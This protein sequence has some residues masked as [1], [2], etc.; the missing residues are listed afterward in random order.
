MAKKSE[1][2]RLPPPTLVIPGVEAASKIQ[3]QI[4]K[5]NGILEHPIGSLEELERLRKEYY[6]W[7]SYNTELLTRF[8]DNQSIADE[9][10]LWIGFAGGRQSPSEEIRDFRRDVQEKISRLQSILERLELISESPKATA[11][12]SL[13][14]VAPNRDVFVVH[15]WDGGARDVVSRFI[16]KLGLRAIVLHEQPSEG[17]TVIEKL[18]AHSDVG[19]AIILLTPDDVGYP[20]NK[21]QE[22]RQRARQNVIFELGYFLGKLGRN[23]VCALHKGEVEL[24]SDYHGV[25]YIR[26]DDNGGWQLRLA[27]EMKQGGM[28][29]DL[30]KVV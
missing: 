28:A 7:S 11:F 21:P 29:V 6:R 26:L 30:N 15:G 17:R 24:P 13:P 3:V 12:S 18:G 5:G 19:S 25:V 14:A 1:Q 27:R 16:D 20:A 8:F 9:Y 2:D 23:R 22:K 4:S 10:D